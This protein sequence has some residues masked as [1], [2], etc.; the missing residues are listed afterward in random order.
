V[1]VLN[2]NRQRRISA[3]NSPR[4]KSGFADD[5]ICA[6][7]MAVAGPSNITPA[8]DCQN[9]YPSPSKRSDP[10]PIRPLTFF[11]GWHRFAHWPAAAGKRFSRGLSRGTCGGVTYREKGGPTCE[12]NFGLARSG[13]C[14][15]FLPA[16]RPPC[17]RRCMAPAPGRSRRQHLGPV[18]PLARWSVPGRT[19][20]A[21]TRPSFADTLTSG[22]NSRRHSDLGHRGFAPVV[23]LFAATGGQRPAAET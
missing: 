22:A 1:F 16:G 10:F 4:R 18:L 23:L 11:G 2:T 5:A 7:L 19:C 15:C 14:W 20:I 12:T 3:E 6:S 9:R 13:L 21:R 8:A 17:S